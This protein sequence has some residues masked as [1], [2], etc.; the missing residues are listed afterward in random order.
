ML[1][2]CFS[3]V[4]SVTQSWRLMPA[5]DRPSAISAR[6]SFSRG[7]SSSSGSSAR[8]AAT[9]SLT[10]VG[11]TTEPPLTIRPSVYELVDVRHPELEEVAAPLA[12]R[13]KLHGV[14]HVHVRR[15]DED[16]SLGELVANRTG[17]LE[18]LGR[19]GRRHSISTIARSG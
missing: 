17:G 14:F 4:P 8:R 11:S 5:F 15:E 10:K 3:T 18:P 7:V 19:V 2:T 1:C 6:T 12:A 9:S 13:E 16:P